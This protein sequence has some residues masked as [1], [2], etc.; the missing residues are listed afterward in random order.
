MIGN[1]SSVQQ[2][3]LQIVDAKKI[4]IKLVHIIM[5]LLRAVFDIA[6]FIWCFVIM[7]FLTNKQ[8]SSFGL[9]MSINLFAS[10]IVCFIEIEKVNRDIIIFKI[11]PGFV[12]ANVYDNMLVSNQKKYNSIKFAYFARVLIAIILC[13]FFYY[14]KSCYDLSRFLCVS[15]K[16]ICILGIVRPFFGWFLSRIFNKKITVEQINRNIMRDYIRDYYPVLVTELMLQQF[17]QSE[18]AI[19]LEIMEVN[20]SVRN[21]NCKHFFHTECI[22]DWIS[23][24]HIC[25]FCRTAINQQPDA[26]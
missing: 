24:H 2:Q 7:F 3:N 12:Y 25:P 15:F 18:C 1:N 8:Q 10:L 11:N 19:C 17:G 26:I 14:E 4:K 9:G 6:L 16:I 5:S 21:L 23:Q 13:Y 20:E 22:D